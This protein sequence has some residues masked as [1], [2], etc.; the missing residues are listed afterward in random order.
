MV[1]LLK[2]L[3]DFEVSEVISTAGYLALNLIYKPAFGDGYMQKSKFIGSCLILIGTTIGA[4]M[5]ALPLVSG[6]PGFLC[7]SILI[8]TIWALMTITGLLVLEV[9]LALDRSACSFSSMANKT[10]GGLGKV[11]TWIIYLLLLYALTAAYM[12][13]AASLLSTLMSSY[14]IYISNFLNAILFTLVLGGTVFWS[15]QSTDYLNR[16]LIGVKGLLLLAS[17]ILLA[18]NVSNSNLLYIKGSI[19][20]KYV[21]DMLPIFLCA[22]GYHT[23]IPSLRIYIGDEPR[24]LRM[25]I[26]SG[27]TISLI[28]YLLWLVVNLGVL[29]LVGEYSFTSINASNGSVKELIA[30]ITLVTQSKRLAVA[31]SGFSN[32]AMATSFLGV[33][34]GL[35]DFLADG[36]NRPNTRYGRAQT[37]LLTFIPPLVFAFYYPQGFLLA[38]KYAAIFATVIGVILPALMAYRLRINK[39]LKSSYN[40]FGGNLLLTAIVVIGAIMVIIQIYQVYVIKN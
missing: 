14:N 15:T 27:T 3:I 10:L 11:V 28:I 17:L 39:N 2:M 36:F 12:S 30:T 18:P 26:I 9:N 1:T 5:L 25:V 6:M 40:V 33:T 32:V 13:G 20:T 31:V 19:T 35:F 24:L 16:G 23:V 38:I 34:L 21:T 37:A 7:A 4:G 22:F 8:I 29:P